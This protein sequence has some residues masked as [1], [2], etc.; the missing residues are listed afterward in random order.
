MMQEKKSRPKFEMEYHY[1]FEAGLTLLLML[2]YFK[3]WY[4]FCTA[5][6]AA[7]FLRV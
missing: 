7:I 1:E 4:F 3:A 6:N 5:S 2:F